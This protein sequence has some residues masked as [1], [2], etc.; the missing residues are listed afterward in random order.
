MVI[1]L[2]AQDVSGENKQI[3]EI[4]VLLT[5]LKLN[6][7]RKYSYFKSLVTLPRLNFQNAN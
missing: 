4:K 3:Y 7:V 1:L 5:E 6:F 2:Q